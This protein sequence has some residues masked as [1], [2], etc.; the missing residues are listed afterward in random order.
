MARSTPAQRDFIGSLLQAQE[1][2]TDVVTFGH[3]PVFEAAGIPWRNGA[4]LDQVLHGLSREQSSALIDQ[5]KED[6]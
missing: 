4:N 1:L 2:P 6:E 3:K 5:L